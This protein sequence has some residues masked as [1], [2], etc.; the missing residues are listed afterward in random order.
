MAGEAG[1]ETLAV[2]APVLPQVRQTLGVTEGEAKGAEPGTGEAGRLAL[3][4][5]G[6]QAGVHG[7]TLS[8][9]QP[10]VLR[11]LASTGLM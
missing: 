8:P 2:T 9:A 4:S 7:E 11:A 6:G 5:T 1:G 3:S 10:P